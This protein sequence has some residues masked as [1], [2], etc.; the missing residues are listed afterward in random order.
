MNSSKSYLHFPT[1]ETDR[2]SLRIIDPAHTNDIFEYAQDPEVSK[3]LTWTPHK[4]ISETKEFIEAALSAY[5]KKIMFVWVI[6]LKETKK[7]IGTISLINFFPVHASCEVGYALS[8][9]YWG[10]G[11]MTEVLN[12]V[13]RFCFEQI[14]I[15]RIE[16]HSFVANIA[17]QQVLKK[18]GFEYEGTLREKMII[19]NKFVDLKLFSILRNDFLNSN[20]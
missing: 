13:V 14:M 6:E 18:C 12:A 5:V 2:Y 17:S 10:K 9:K 20:K 3:F 15:N 8:Q 16:A 19:K 11:I 7:V 1:I 4:N